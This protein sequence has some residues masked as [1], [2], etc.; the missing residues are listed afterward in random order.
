MKDCLPS[1]LIRSLLGRPSQ[2]GS[3]EKG[4]ASELTRSRILQAAF[5]EMYQ[6]GYQGMRIETV[7]A[8]T[9]L[10]KGALYH[11][12]KNKKSLAYAVVDE[13]FKTTFLQV[14]QTVGTVDDPLNEICAILRAQCQQVTAADIV[15]GCPLNNLSQEMAGLDDGFKGRLSNIYE[16]W[17]QLLS[18]AIAEAQLRGTVRSSIEPYTVAAFLISSIQGILGT[19]K[20]LQSKAML[21]GLTEALCDYVQYLRIG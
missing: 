18:R 1:R 19:S 5:E 2:L 14:W 6:H 13:L 16:C 7:L 3:A 20:C 10:A 15:Q 8:K 17:A 11:H 21:E 9:G 4:A 12:F